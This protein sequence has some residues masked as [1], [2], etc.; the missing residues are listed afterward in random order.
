MPKSIV[1]L[2]QE[3]SCIQAVSRFGKV[4]RDFG[5]MDSGSPAA[6][7][8]ETMIGRGQAAIARHC[9]APSRALSGPKPAR[10]RR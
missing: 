3:G 5:R 7:A 9:L 6:S 10:K 8:A 4:N 1:E 2:A